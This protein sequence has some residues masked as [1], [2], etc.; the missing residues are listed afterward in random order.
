M[1]TTDIY[2]NIKNPLDSM[3]LMRNLFTA[4]L[5]TSDFDKFYDYIKRM[6]ETKNFTLENEIVG[7]EAHKK[8]L[9]FMFN[10]WRKNIL[11]TSL[12]D[13]PTKKYVNLNEYINTR[14]LLKDMSD[15]EFVSTN[16][17]ENG[18]YSWYKKDI[19]YTYINSYYLNVIE[20]EEITKEHV[21]YININ[22][23][24]ALFRV[25]ESFVIQ[26]I[27]YKLPF[28]FKYANN[29]NNDS[30]LV[31]FSDTK[32]LVPYVNILK[33]ICNDKELNITMCP[34]KLLSGVID[35]YIGYESYVYDDLEKFTKERL[36]IIYEVLNIEIP[37]LYDTRFRKDICDHKDL[38][39]N[40]YIFD[41]LLK[42]K[43]RILDRKEKGI[44][45]FVKLK[46]IINIL[47]DTSFK[48]LKDTT[49]KIGIKDKIVI[50]R[51]EIINLYIELLNTL[52]RKYP[53]YIKR[54]VSKIEILSED[55]R[56]DRYTFCFDFS[57]INKISQY[58][59]GRNIIEIDTIED[60]NPKVN[61]LK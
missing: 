1:S 16:N 29:I 36:Q 8:F 26:C 57:T 19:D 31:I 7:E 53:M 20:E 9:L 24:S 25:I 28:D 42:S 52:I 50:E 48:K 60:K 49:L 54:I 17:K 43:E 45:S 23:K 32:L 59:Y 38:T 37:K 12:E 51:N 18:E 2:E 56:I 35:K 47:K 13:V 46:R 10:I 4:Y 15:I 61:V 33:N 40:D 39:F 11:N 27:K 3:N 6:S 41:E 55:F 21:L 44:I 58:E 22:S 34:P 5:K 30:T 14:E